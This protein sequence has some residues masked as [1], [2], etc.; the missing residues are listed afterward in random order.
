MKK[1]I[2]KINVGIGFVTGRKNF[3]KVAKAYLSSYSM[4]E[5][6]DVKLYAL[7]LF[8]AYDL[9]YKGTQVSDYQITDEEILD[10][11]DSVHYLGP[12]AISAEA[13]GLVKDKVIT[14]KEAK[15]VF[16]EGYAMKRN[17]VLYFA[18]KN[19]MD[20]IVFLDD[21]E[22][23]IANVRL[24]NGL[25]WKGQETLWTHIQGIQHADMTHGYH[26]GYISPIPQLEFNKKLSEEDF[27]IFIEAI[28]NDII[29]W[30]SIK[31]KMA[32]GGVTYAAPESKESGLDIWIKNVGG[33]KFISGANLAIRLKDKKKVFPF[34]N[35][36]GAR[37]E[38][39]FLSTCID[40]CQV[41]KV[42][43]YT[44]HDAFSSY[45]Q[46]LNGV[47][48]KTLK[49]IDGKKPSVVKRFQQ[50]AVGWIRYKPL[51]VYITQPEQ[52]EQQMLEVEY[53]LLCIVPK[54]CQYF[55]NNDFQ[56]ILKEFYR[57]RKYVADHFADFENT[58]K[59]WVKIMVSFEK[60]AQGK[61]R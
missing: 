13:D 43:C 12:A 29:T 37:G 35:P 33:M 32:D 20:S 45:D 36:P 61:K 15:T 49:V 54:L 23:P 24:D 9:K 53:A 25:A 18:V 31:E 3:K 40:S 38:D 21:D 34:Y 51:L 1:N 22:Y 11:V 41:L 60:P 10:I 28:S 56:M 2:R 48:P 50:A 47:L 8:V 55:E 7:H 59:A 39:T 52:Y 14:A 26:C 4:S 58:K 17:A 30:A 57:Y 5:D 46:L 19:K 44:F 27:Q 6:L 42:G 16:G